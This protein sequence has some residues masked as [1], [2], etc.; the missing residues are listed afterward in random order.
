MARAVLTTAVACA[1]LSGCAFSDGSPWAEWDAELDVTLDTEGRGTMASFVTS[2]DYEVAITSLS[3]N[4]VDVGLEVAAGAE[5]QS[6]DPSSPPE[7]YGLCHNGHCHAD[8]GALVPYEEIRAELTGGGVDSVWFVRG[9]QTIVPI[10]EAT[11]EV[12]LAD[13]DSQRSACWLPRGEITRARARVDSLQVSGF[14]HDLR[15]T[16]PRLS[17]PLEFDISIIDAPVVFTTPVGE[18]IGGRAEPA[19][20]TQISLRVPASLFDDLPWQSSSELDERLAEALNESQTL[21][22]SLER[23]DF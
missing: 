8:N 2:D 13:C 18:R 19:I 3:L 9:V 10:D 6:F 20:Y 7:G 5:S 1:T 22:V 12:A 11:T 23:R 15:S 14:V 4:V 17:E 16:N 21:R